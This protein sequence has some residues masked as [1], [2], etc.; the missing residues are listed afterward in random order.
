MKRILVNVPNDMAYS[1]IFRQHVK[2]NG[3]DDVKHNGGSNRAE[4]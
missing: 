4:E 1:K 3:K 2:N